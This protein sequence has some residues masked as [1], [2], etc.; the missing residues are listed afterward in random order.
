VEVINK[1]QNREA[2]EDQFILKS[3]HQSIDKLCDRIT[4]VEKKLGR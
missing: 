4:E 2:E 3:L 1:S